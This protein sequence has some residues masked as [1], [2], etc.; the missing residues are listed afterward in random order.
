MQSYPTFPL[1]DLPAELQREIF[2]M[3]TSNQLSCAL[4]L[5]L[6]AR[7]VH[8]WVQPLVYEIVTLGADDTAL[9]LRTMDSKPSEFFATHVKQLCLAVSVNPEDAAR[10][11]AVC[12]GVI[13]LAFW[14]DYLAA[15]SDVPLSALITSLSLRRLSIEFTHYLDLCEISK[16]SSVNWRVKLTHLHVIFWADEEPA[17]IPHLECLSCLTHF[18]LRL[19]YRQL[20]EGSIS[21]ILASCKSLRI[22]AILLDELDLMQDLAKFEDKRVVFMPY[23]DAVQDWEASLRGLPDIWSRAEEMVRGHEGS[24]QR[25]PAAHMM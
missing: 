10:I 14:V 7:R 1:N 11:L 9:F 20:T 6:V 17:F 8:E 12:T 19:R 24:S 16:P 3:A 5:S 13:G 22:L 21:A 4:R 25:G 15:A 18:S 23:P 2:S